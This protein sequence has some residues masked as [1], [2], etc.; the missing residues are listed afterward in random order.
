MN[1]KKLIIEK[2]GELKIDKIGFTDA[3]V[4]ER[5]Q[6]ELSKRAGI[7]YFPIAPGKI[8]KKCTPE[9]KLPGAQTVIVGA[10]N[11]FTEKVFAPSVPLKGRVSPYTHADYYQAL[12]DKLKTLAEFIGK[13]TGSHGFY[14]QSCYGELREKEFAARA[15]L[16][17]YGRNGVIMTRE[18]GAWVVLGLLVTDL[19]IE[20]DEPLSNPCEASGCRKCIDSCPTGAIEAPYQ[21]NVFKC[22]QGVTE[23]FKSVPDELKSIWGDRFY[24]CSICLYVC[25]FNKGVINSHQNLPGAIEVPVDLKAVL[26]MS[27]EEFQKVYGANQIGQRRKKEALQRNAVL[28]LGNSQ[29]PAAFEIISRFADNRDCEIMM[30]ACDWAMA[31]LQNIRK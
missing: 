28:A 9:G 15:G 16:G 2:A 19:F 24:G 17:W 20:R 21:V 31:R 30:D 26:L 27:D 8:W 18:F 4:L 6:L 14:C 25:P 12:E 13:E 23:N 1:L 10:L 5:T 22:L 3:S 7:S 11:Y 29:C